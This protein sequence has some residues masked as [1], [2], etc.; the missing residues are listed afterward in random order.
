MAQKKKKLRVYVL[1][2]GQSAEHDVSVNTGAM[3]LKNLDPKK[4]LVTPVFIT[5]TGEWL[6]GEHA[7][8]YM[9][10]GTGVKPEAGA[11]EPIRQKQISRIALASGLRRRL[12]PMT[13]AHDAD[14]IRR[15]SALGLRNYRTELSRARNEESVAFIAMHGPYGEDGTIQGLLELAGIPYTG[16][17]VL[18]SALAMDKVVSADVF[19][20]Q[21]LRVPPYVAFT[22][23]DWT[24]RRGALHARISRLGWP[25]VVKPRNLGSSVGITIV[26][27][28][29]ALAAAVRRAA[30]HSPQLMAQQYIRG[31]ELTCGVIDQGIPGTEMAL[32]PTEIIPKT[33]AFFDYRAKYTAGASEEI[34]PP[35]LPKPM[36]GKIQETALTAHRALGCSGMSRTD[37]ILKDGKLYVLEVNTIP[38][39]T[40][41]SL[42]PQAAN[43]CGISFPQLLERII[44]A[45]L[46]RH[47]YN[48]NY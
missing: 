16:S 10:I 7:R 8:G 43:A 19:R 33:S 32:Q 14:R 11:S 48:N 18:A 34:T 28:P 2:G 42:L 37:M 15:P 20:Q 21:G 41:T 26:S 4:F 24:K 31:K 45:A 1:M 5:K 12:A 40:E 30:A 23:A 38:G 27:K 29:S 35:R 47:R 9:P 46:N 22:H 25:L 36:I 44:L 6:A 39:M 3:V 17:G 13:R